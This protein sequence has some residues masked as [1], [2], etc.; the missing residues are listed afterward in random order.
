MSSF[1]SQHR[2]VM[3]DGVV[4]ERLPLGYAAGR[5]WATFVYAPPAGRTFEAAESRRIGYTA[6]VHEPDGLLDCVSG[7]GGGNDDQFEHTWE[8]VD[9][10]AT[11][12]SVGYG[13]GEADEVGSEQL[14]LEPGDRDPAFAVR[15][16]DGSL[17]ERLPL[18]HA[19]G[20]WRLRWV[21]SDVPAAE[22]ARAYDQD[23]D[24]DGSMIRPGDRFVRLRY[25]DAPRWMGAGG[26][27]GG[28]V[29]PFFTSVPDSVTHV[30]VDYLLDDE[31]VATEVVPLPP[32][33]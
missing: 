20:S 12:V 3:P 10:G 31:L 22:V 14:V 1:G 19:R 24:D 15:L 4:V 13:T 27:V 17:V 30:E 29:Q 8:L 2:H 16:P 26:A 6:W 5:W 11:R 32:S 25:V 18:G 23:E 7:A 21:R 33:P 28:A 9:K